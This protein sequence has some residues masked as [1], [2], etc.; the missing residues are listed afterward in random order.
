ME[1]SDFGQS[2]ALETLAAGNAGWKGACAG[3][4]GASPLAPAGTLIDVL[5]RNAHAHPGKTAFV[6]LKDGEH[7]AARLTFGELYERACRVGTALRRLGA[8]GER[9][10]LLY[11][12][13]LD[14]IVAF[15]GTLHA[16]AVAVPGPHN[17]NSR[18]SR[19]DA[20]LDDSA[21]A[22]AMTV[23][24]MTAEIAPILEARRGGARLLT[25][26]ELLDL[27]PAAAAEQAPALA[28]EALAL[29]QFTSGSTRTPKGVMITHHNIMHNQS[30]IRRWF[31]HSGD[32]VFVSWLPMF[33]DMGLIG[34]TL[35]PVY[36]GCQCVVMSPASFLQEPSR[37]L[38]A[39]TRYRGTT[40]GSPN[41]GYDF[42]VDRIGAE[43]RQS[44][45]LSTWDIAY[46]GSEP[47]KARTLARFTEAFAPH[48][49]SPAAFYPCYGMAEATLLVSGGAKSAEPFTREYQAAPLPGGAPEPARTIV[50]CGTT[51]AEHRIVIVDP[52]TLK[53]AP[54]G[55]TGEIWLAGPSISPGYWN[56]PE[57]TAEA[58]GLTL[59]GMEPWRFMR[60]GDLG[61][62]DSG[63]L[64][65]TGR[66]KELIIVRG[67]NH[68]P[69]DIEETAQGSHPA[70]RLGGGAA[71]AVEG[72]EIPRIVLVNEIAR[73]YLREPPVAE[74]AARVR[75]A[76]S[77][78]H[79]LQ[80]AAVVLIKPGAIPK[81]SSGKIQR[82]LC[83]TRF[84]AGTLAAV[85]E[86]RIGGK[87]FVGEQTR[88]AHRSAAAH[89]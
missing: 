45:D 47:V 75:A 79:G 54:D 60:T 31:E 89:V 82:G 3:R 27:V 49:F 63:H 12:Q 76:V 8:A 26:E 41:F 25:V 22:F 52:E 28:G 17:T 37:W 18:T 50:G 7:E 78:E 83:R 48:G 42:C 14:F 29:L 38:R 6:F 20:I 34:N 51:S 5:R 71:F 81:T 77:R 56:R 30:L 53:P 73:Q 23:P 32:T 16:G 13:S 2:S 35:Q 33:H 88:E 21:P 74:I 65:V 86:D 69:H 4:S 40:A 44:L 59:D 10:L 64:F 24:G 72:G 68:Y 9:V 87:I 85:A 15:L 36:V 58:F 43:Q 57:E 39:I 67:R 80:V 62:M 66:I 84:L 55:Q 11:P 1:R 61:L 46:N 70:L 19:I